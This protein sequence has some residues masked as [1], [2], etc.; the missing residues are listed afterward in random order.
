M[1]HWSATWQPEKSPLLKLFNSEDLRP[2]SGPKPKSNTSANSCP[3]SPTAGKPDTPNSVKNKRH[4]RNRPCLANQKRNNPTTA[5][6]KPRANGQELNQSG[7]VRCATTERAL[8]K[9]SP[10]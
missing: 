8:T 5:G 9:K 1:L 7:N 4:R 10:S 2:I 3:R 6:Q